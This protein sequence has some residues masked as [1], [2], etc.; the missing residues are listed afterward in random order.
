MHSLGA[1]IP[2]KLSIETNP[3]SVVISKE[4]SECC[5]KSIFVPSII[6]NITLGL[7]GRK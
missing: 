5:C 4:I 7:N 2:L 3:L 6:K 1:I